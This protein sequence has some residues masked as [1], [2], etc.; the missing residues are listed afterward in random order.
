MPRAKP[1]PSDRRSSL[2]KEWASQRPGESLSLQSV[3]TQLLLLG[4]HISRD[5]DR[6]ARQL[7]VTGPELR[8][9][10]ALRR[11]GAPYRLRP[12]DLLDALLVPSS[13]MA[14]QLERLE[15]QGLV[16]RCADPQDGRAKL[17]E[18]ADGGVAA[19]DKA[20][21]RM[22]KQSPISQG[23]MAMDVRRVE[24]LDALLQEVLANLPA[25]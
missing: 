22:L 24:T 5:N 7:G 6:V 16:R 11:R 8:V 3:R 9:L 13:S 14:R 4:A 15:S 12:A 19:A 17:V 2:M 25:G 18:L 10:L 23:L 1:N 20:I 21:S